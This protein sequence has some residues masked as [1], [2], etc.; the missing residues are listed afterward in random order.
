MTLQFILLI[1]VVAFIIWRA[2]T[3]DESEGTTHDES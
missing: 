1:I 3:E 2:S